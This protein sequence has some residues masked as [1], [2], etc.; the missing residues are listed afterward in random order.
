MKKVANGMFVCVEYTGTLQN[1]EVFDTSQGCPP[2]EIE[3]G[4]GQLIHGFE[5]QLMNMSLNEKKTFTVAPEDDS[6]SSQ[7]SADR[8][9]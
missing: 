1:G 8:L 4:A 3:M 7:H 6:L 5:A 9:T 2:L